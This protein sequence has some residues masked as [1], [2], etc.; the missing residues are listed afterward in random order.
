MLV[1]V[2][3]GVHLSER[4][5]ELIGDVF[6][7]VP[8]GHQLVDVEDSH[9][10]PG[11]P[12]LAAENVRRPRS[13]PSLPFHWPRSRLNVRWRIRRRR[14]KTPVSLLCRPVGHTGVGDV[15]LRPLGR[16]TRGRRR[17]P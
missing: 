11:D 16:R 1:V 3:R 6:R 14:R 8:G 5:L 13:L 10:R 7:V 12:W 4:E 2:E 9:S 15:H 17:A